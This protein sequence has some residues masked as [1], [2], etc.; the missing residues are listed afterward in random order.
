MA[1]IQS[2]CI[3]LTGAWVNRKYSYIADVATI[4]GTITVASLAKGTNSV[5]NMVVAWADVAAL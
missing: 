2:A 3:D 4:E 5:V 1:S